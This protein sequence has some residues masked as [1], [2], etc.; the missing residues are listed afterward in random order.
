MSFS[1]RL[2]K[3]EMQKLFAELCEE[4]VLMHINPNEVKARK[5]Q[6]KIETEVSDLRRKMDETIGKNIVLSN[7]EIRLLRYL[8]LT[9][10]EKEK[11]KGSYKVAKKLEKLESMGQDKNDSSDEDEEDEKNDDAEYPSLDSYTSENSHSGIYQYICNIINTYKSIKI[12]HGFIRW[13]CIPP[14]PRA[15]KPNGINADGGRD[16]GRH[17]NGWLREDRTPRSYTVGSYWFLKRH[18]NFREHQVVTDKV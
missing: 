15:T 10:E 17:S 18:G 1:R 11:L 14:K 4:Q 12:I 8:E 7:R 2:L 3:P 6:R 16:F 9:K 5:K 13:S